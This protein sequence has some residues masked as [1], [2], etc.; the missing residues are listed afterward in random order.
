MKWH[1]PSRAQHSEGLTNELKCSGISPWRGCFLL[2]HWW[3]WWH[4][5]WE[6]HQLGPSHAKQHYPESG[7]Q[8]GVVL[9]RRKECW[10][11]LGKCSLSLS[12]SLSSLLARQ[13]SLMNLKTQILRGFGWSSRACSRHHQKQRKPCRT[14]SHPRDIL[15]QL[16]C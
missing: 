3:R 8:P 12:L 6:W 4:W 1:F 2:W 5:W 16:V 11:G 13:N 7:P 14:S 15:I 10:L 9:V